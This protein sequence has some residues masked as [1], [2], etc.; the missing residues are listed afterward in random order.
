[1]RDERLAEEKMRMRHAQMPCGKW[2][3]L[4]EYE[5]H[6]LIVMQL[7]FL[8][9]RGDEHSWSS[10]MIAQKPVFACSRRYQREVANSRKEDVGVSYKKKEQT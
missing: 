2:R 5:E 7:L 6:A 4:L 10:G 1:M 9:C 8:V 3:K